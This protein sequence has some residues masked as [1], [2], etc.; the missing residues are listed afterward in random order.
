MLVSHIKLFDISHDI[1]VM[2]GQIVPI[3]SFIL[4][5]PCFNRT[6]QHLNLFTII[7]CV[8]NTEQVENNKF[9]IEKVIRK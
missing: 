3:N 2:T 6:N 5:T 1:V 4:S 7:F 8:V 9:Y